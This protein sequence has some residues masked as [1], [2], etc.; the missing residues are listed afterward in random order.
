MTKIVRVSLAGCGTVGGAFIELLGAHGD[1]LLRRHGI[2]VM[3]SR[4]L[5]RSP[6]RVRGVALDPALLTSDVEEFLHAPSDVVVEAIG[7]VDA[8]SRIAVE[9]LTTGRRLIT[10]NKALLRAV[11]PTLAD[12]AAR[13]RTRG[14]ALEFEAAVGGGVPVVRLLRDGLAGHG[15]RCVRGVLNGTTNF[16]LSRMERGASFAK[17]LQAARRLGFAEADPRRD[18]EGVDAADKIAV[19]AWIAFGVD[20]SALP[21]RV[22]ALPPELG[23]LL[24]LAAR[25]DRRVRLLATVRCVGGAVHAHVAPALL[26][27]SHAFARAVDE[28]NVIEIDSA[29]AGRIL[30]GG[31][32]AGGAATASALLAD[33]IRSAS[34][35]PPRADLPLTSSGSLAHAS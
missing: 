2:R 6:E 24:A 10:A 5:V 3:L 20:P 9:S 8:A 26:P 7:G 1:G 11:G 4:V 22:R 27:A 35:I 13:Y 28:E 23:P 29:S 17:A 16:I 31:R 32:G 18:L 12:L 25:R 15:V 30:V 14:A 33:L 21:V 19:L 34:P